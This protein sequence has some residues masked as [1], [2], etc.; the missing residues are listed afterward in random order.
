[1]KKNLFNT[2]WDM[3]KVTPLESGQDQLFIGLHLIHEVTS[4]Q[5]FQM[6]E[7]RGLKV[8][9]P[10]RTFAT[11]DHIVP[12][13]DQGRPFKDR[14]AEEMLQ[15]IES[16]TEKHGIDFFGLNSDSQG[17][18]HIIGPELGLTQ[19][20]MTIACGDSHTSTHGAFG[21][22][23]LRHR[24]LPDPGRAGN[25]DDGV[26][27]SQSTTDRDLRTPSAGGIRKRYHPES[28][29]G[30]RRKRRYRVRLRVQRRDDPRSR[31]GRAD[32]DL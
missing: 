10:D 19:P 21:G 32:D 4:P 24:D 25:S 20:G 5:A 12:T 31:Y 18:V 2:V 17:I 7:E 23:R 16:N 14:L 11:V 27:S 1:M 15:A 13:A 30:S 3:H 26:E 28:H 8:L 9:R 22:D 6:V 29:S